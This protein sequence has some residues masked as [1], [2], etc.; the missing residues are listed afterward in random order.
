MHF[1]FR[2]DFSIVPLTQ[3]EIKRSVASPLIR[4]VVVSIF[5][6]SFRKKTIKYLPTKRRGVVHSMC[7]TN[8]K[9]LFENTF[10]CTQPWTPDCRIRLLPSGLHLPAILAVQ[11]A[12]ISCLPRSYM[13]KNGPSEVFG[14][15]SNNRFEHVTYEKSPIKSMR[16]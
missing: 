13:R 15:D 11:V 12:V 9:S 10:G 4:I 8:F 5:I 2:I 6:S 16:N 1:F 7:Q 14:I 3:L